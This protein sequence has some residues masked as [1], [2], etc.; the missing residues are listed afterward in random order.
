MVVIMKKNK[1][2]SLFFALLLLMPVLPGCS[3]I[4]IQPP[5]Q[6]TVHIL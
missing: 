4:I 5:G 1:L 3:V 6:L 2:L